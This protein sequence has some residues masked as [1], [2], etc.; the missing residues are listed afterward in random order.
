MVPTIELEMLGN[1]RCGSHILAAI[2]FVPALHLSPD[3]LVGGEVHSDDLFVLALVAVERTDVRACFCALLVAGLAQGVATRKQRGFRS[4]QSACAAN[5]V[6][7]K[8]L[9]EVQGPPV[10]LRRKSGQRVLHASR[11]HLPARTLTGLRTAAPARNPAS[12]G[13]AQC[14]FLCVSVKW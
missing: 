8:R 9:Q 7:W 11:R 13:G 10:Q 14:V 5:P 1:P 6:R 2:S 12:S 3:Q 4:H